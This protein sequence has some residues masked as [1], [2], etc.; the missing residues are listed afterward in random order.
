M[1]AATAGG[2]AQARGG[3]GQVARLGA[4]LATVFVLAHL[5]FLPTAL[6]DVDAVNF[7]LGLREFDPTKHQ[8]HPP[9]YPVYIAMGRMSAAVLHAA[10][11]D[12]ADERVETRALAIWSVL[13]G[14]VAALALSA[15]FGALGGVS[16]GPDH[17]AV[18]AVCGA[19]LALAAP[20]MWVGGVRPMSDLP[21][22]AAALIAQ[23]L[24]ARVLM[25]VAG[26]RALIAGAVVAGLALGIRTQAL[27]LTAPLI[28]WA[29][30]AHAIRRDWRTVTATFGGAVA[31]CLAWAVPLVVASGGWSRYRA[32]L[33]SQAGEDFASADML[34]THP[35]ARR[36]AAGLYESFVLPWDRPLLAGLVL[37]LAAGG[38]VI[39][40]LRARRAAFVL[41]TGF[42]P[43]AVFHL[44][45]QEAAH[46]RYALPLVVPVAYLAVVGF[47][48]ASR[49]LVVPGTIILAAAC[50]VVATPAIVTYASAPAPEQLAVSDMVRAERTSAP[51][52]VVIHHS[53]ARALQPTGR[54]QPWMQRP[55]Y[56]HE[57]E[58]IL[59][60]WQSGGAAPVWLLADTQ[61]VDLERLQLP[62][63]DR[64]AWRDRMVYRW[65]LSQSA[66]FGG[67]RP[68]DVAWY[69][70][71]RP[72]WWL[73]LGWALT[74]ELGGLGRRAGRSPAAGL[75]GHVRRENGPVVVQVGGR[76]LGRAEDPP[77]AFDLAIDGR[78]IE[79]WTVTPAERA[80]LK[81]FSWRSVPAGAGDYAELAVTAHAPDGTRPVSES[82]I[83]QFDLQPAGALVVGYGRGWHEPEV[84]A[85][86][87]RHRPWRWTSASSDLVVHNGAAGQHL[88]LR[89]EGDAPRGLWAAAPVA[90]VRV[91]TA[92][93][94]RAALERH[95]TWE[96]PID[97]HALASAGGVVTI[98]TSPT[99]SPAENGR[100]RDA[101]RLGLR[102]FVCDVTPR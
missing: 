60:Y 80:F 24:V 51:G 73:D 71:D 64:T 41:M 58:T 34:W 76:H 37:G 2:V 79:R 26:R 65:P 49:R 94:A 96:I 101:R 22:L 72:R 63:V 36:L 54:L 93:L 78:V 100:S 69:R 20:L 16:P 66:V 19:G 39:L 85:Q 32:A 3:R 29:T 88:L 61:R 9:G 11:A 59:D 7:A 97:A 17:V 40:A 14:A 68:T 23:A 1:H 98:E 57:W 18:V 50:L 91:G 62:L 46:V 47:R 56:P 5:P 27:W 43:Y 44:L 90:L 92:V 86:G 12:T 53:V 8:P 55:P 74:P 33:N 102:I 52:L 6:E 82:A 15:L 45:F 13:G 99:F 81:L 28:A 38:C 77:V 42:A 95:F 31:S 83:E 67:T 25:G 87:T 75:T 10:G 70:I 21:G 30:V 48:G 35:T 4:A 89:L 84:E